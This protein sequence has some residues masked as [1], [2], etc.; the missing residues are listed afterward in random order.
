MHNTEWLQG[1]GLAADERGVVCDTFCRVLD[2]QGQAIEG[3]FV[4]GD[5]ARWPQHLCDGDL[6]AVEHWGNAVD[7]A[8]NAAHN[9][10]SA[11]VN[12][13]EYKHIPSFWSSQ[14]GINIK[15]A[16]LPNLG[17]EVMVTQ[18]SVEQYR[19]VAAYGRQGRVIGA[20]TF[21]QGRWLEA[22]N[23]LIET[24]AT[25]PPQFSA[26][27]QPVDMQSQKAGFPAVVQHA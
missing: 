6:I 7:Q 22:Y 20:V 19:F 13:Q 18:G 1:S 8:R 12:Y 27:D 3:I 4:A 14:F 15:S 16:G 11:T 17:D 2:T 21:D 10:L 25:Y 26:P 23:T 24:G 9:M 5:V